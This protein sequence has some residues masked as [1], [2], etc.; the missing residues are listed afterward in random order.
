MFVAGMISTDNAPSLPTAMSNFVP[1]LITISDH[2]QVPRSRFTPC[3][4]LTHQL[5]SS[6]F[7]PLAYSNC[8]DDGLFVPVLSLVGQHIISNCPSCT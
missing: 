8:F 3:S 6:Q 4:V 5:E 7:D 1:P 2:I